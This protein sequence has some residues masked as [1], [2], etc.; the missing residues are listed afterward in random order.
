MGCSGA[1]AQ[2]RAALARRL[3]VCR[4]V[5][6]NKLVETFLQAVSQRRISVQLISHGVFYG[7]VSCFC[8]VTKSRAGALRA[9]L[10]T[11]C[12]LPRELKAYRYG[13][14]RG[15]KSASHHAQKQTK[16]RD[17]EKQTSHNYKTECHYSE[18]IIVKSCRENY[19]RESMYL[20]N[21]SSLHNDKKLT[22]ILYSFSIF[23]YVLCPNDDITYGRTK[24]ILFLDILK[25]EQQSL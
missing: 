22:Y 7:E 9:K 13:K 11:N 24:Y 3:T 12:P 2:S 21:I 25:L 4:T 15:Q 18:I 5:Y 1:R 8:S 14:P 6:L 17:N 16:N 23:K 20:L 10:H 19:I